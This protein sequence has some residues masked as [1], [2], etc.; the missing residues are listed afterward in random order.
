MIGGAD[1]AFT[2]GAERLFVID[3]GTSSAIF[4]FTAANADEAVTVDELSLL[5]IVNGNANL[6]ASDFTLF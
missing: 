1:A 3:N 2:A 4:Q 5:A 6:G